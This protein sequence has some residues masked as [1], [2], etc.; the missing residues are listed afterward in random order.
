MT[1]IFTDDTNHTVSSDDFTIA[2]NSLY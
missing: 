1:T 2:T